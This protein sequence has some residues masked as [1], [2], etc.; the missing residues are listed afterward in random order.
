MIR[1]SAAAKRRASQQ[2]HPAEKYIGLMS[3]TSMDSIDGVLVDFSGLIPRV[4]A[5]EQTPLDSGLKQR[6]LALCQDQSVELT[7]YIAL[8]GLLGQLFAHTALALLTETSTLPKEIYAIGSHGQTIAH[9]PGSAIPGSLQLGDP[10]IIATQTNI[11][12]VADFRRRDMAAGGQGAPL[13]PA[14]HQ[15]VFRH[16]EH[17]RVVLNIGG[18]ANITILPANPQQP[19]SGFDTGPGN[20]LLDYWAT[21]HLGTTMDHAGQWAASG[22]VNQPLL[23]AMLQDQYF[24]QAPPKS[25]GRELFNSAWLRS[26][27][28]NHGNSLSAADI[29]ATLSE[30]TASSIATAIL[31]YAPEND[32]LLICGGGVHNKHLMKCLA[33]HLPHCPLRSTAYFGIDPDYVEAIAFAWLAR[34]TIAGRPGNVPSVTGAQREMILGGIYKGREKIKDKR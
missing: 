20:L 6:L 5:T 8:D 27:L 17:N 4:L 9:Y 12:T 19:I 2:D 23:K 26:L 18:I 10:N 25:T 22:T 1:K 31:S 28:Q 34:Q 21:Q 14:F 24:Q 15:A 11:T 29:Q 30:L 7:E 32:A 33:S 16:A 13:V 3:G